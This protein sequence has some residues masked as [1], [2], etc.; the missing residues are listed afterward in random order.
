MLNVAFSDLFILM[1]PPPTPQPQPPVG[2]GY[3]IAVN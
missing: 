2:E 1:Q 3:I